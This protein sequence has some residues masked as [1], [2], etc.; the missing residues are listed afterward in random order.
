MDTPKFEKGDR[1]FITSVNAS[2]SIY[3]IR[4]GEAT[5]GILYTV[6]LDTPFFPNEPFFYAREFELKEIHTL[7]PLRGQFIGV[8]PSE[9]EE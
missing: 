8:D 4:N 3:N 9:F 5:G 1:V 7:Q 2:G 6:A